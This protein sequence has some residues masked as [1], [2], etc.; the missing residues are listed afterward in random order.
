M[1]PL[2]IEAI[3]QKV[4]VEFTYNE[5]RRK[6]AIYAYGVNNSGNLIIR[7]YQTRNVL[8][9]NEIGCRIFKED[10]IFDLTLTDTK[11]YHALK[12]KKGD[13]MMNFVIAQLKY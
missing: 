11:F 2:I 9:S 8:R 4:Y 6:V 3:T 10:K 7:G 13:K 12:Y 5:T 1:N